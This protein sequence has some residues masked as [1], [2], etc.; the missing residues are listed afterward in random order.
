MNFEGKASEDL[1][2]DKIKQLVQQKCFTDSGKE[3]ANQ[4]KMLGNVGKIINELRCT[5]E[6]LDS[7]NNIAI[8]SIQSSEILKEI[9]LLQSKHGV[10][11]E[12]LL[13]NLRNISSSV[14]YFIR[15]F[16]K[17]EELYPNLR[18]RTEKVFITKEIVDAINHVLDGK[19]IVKSSASEKLSTI[20]KNLVSYRKQVEKNFQAE[21][22]KY[23]QAE[24]LDDTRESFVQGR[25]VLAV[26]SEHKRKVKGSILGSSTTG[27]VTFIEPHINVQINNE[28]QILQQE[29]RDEIYRILRVLTQDLKVHLPLIEA[30]QELLVDFDFIQAKAHFAKEINAKYPVV[31]KK[32]QLELLEAY[33]PLLYLENS[34]SGEKTLPQDITLNLEKRILVISGPNAGGKSITLKTV[35]LLQI[36]LQ[37][38]LLIPV[39]EQSKVTLFQNI[40]TDIGDNQSIENKLSTYSYRLQNMKYFLK[41]A[42]ARTLFLIDEFGTGSDPELGGA[43]AEVFFE[44]LYKSQAFGVIT[45]HYSNIKILTDKFEATENACMLFDKESL[46]PL[47]QLA[48]GQPGSSFT[49]EVAYKNGIPHH[50]IREAKERVSSGKLK[51]DQ[52]IAAL[53]KEKAKIERYQKELK[54]ARNKA[55]EAEENLD[56]RREELEFKLIRLQQTQHDNNNY[57]NSGKRF[58]ELLS[59]YNGKNIK[60]TVAKFVKILKIEWTKKETAKKEKKPQPKLTPIGKKR[61]EK[62]QQIEKKKTWVPVSV[63]DRVKMDGSPQAG[64][65]IEIEKDTA[66]VNFGIF[67]TKVSVKKLFKV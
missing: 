6:Y 15:F 40:L 60:T 53:Q 27:K 32:P 21:L 38:G 62:K 44:Q 46:E 52:S 18:Q 24:W 25:R 11:Q 1:E 20:R 51:L 45:T 50:L 17:N 2:F 14:N 28:T 58:I 23:R 26:L 31:S 9:E 5:N 64:E 19:C 42:N 63:G 34:K 61:E 43:L 37:S 36:M 29:E 67:K 30:Y 49:F 65:V 54:S 4:I 8:P 41:K 10:L 12:E 57:I 55:L 48:I 22:S 7:L 3:K 59:S 56:L 16:I 35:G 33:H 13:G 47:Y 66:T 39:K